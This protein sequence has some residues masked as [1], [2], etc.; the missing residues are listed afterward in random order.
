VTPAPPIR[1]DALVFG[2]GNSA[3]ADDGLG[4]A[5]LDH[6]SSVEGFH[7][8][9]EYRYQLQVE[10]AALVADADQVVFVDACCSKLPEGFCWTECE[11]SADF[12]FS[13]H[14]LPPRSVLSLSRDLYGRTPPATLLMIQGEEWE[15]RTGLGTAAQ[16]HLDRALRSFQVH[17]RGN[18]RQS[19]RPGVKPLCGN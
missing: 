9:A 17:L 8:Q 10:D 13:T 19:V 12:P 4:W 15:L 3:R 1:A 5:F 18:G 14:A 7:G 6:L 2:I 16:R 11:P